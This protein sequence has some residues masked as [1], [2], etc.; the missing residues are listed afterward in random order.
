MQVR[1]T[2]LFDVA[3]VG[4]GIVGLATAW[5]ILQRR[6]STRLI[7]LEKEARVAMHQSSRNSG[8]IHSG[9]YYRPGSLRAQNCLRG[10]RLLLD[11]C[12]HHD[13]PYAICGKLI[14]ATTE[15]ERPPLE[16]LHRRG[17]E[18]GLTGV[19]LLSGAEAREIEPY[20]N[21]AAALWVPQTGI[22]DYGAVARQLAHLVEQAGGLIRVNAE[23]ER[24]TPSSQGL[25]IGARSWEGTARY[26]VTCAGL[27]ADRLARR[28]GAQFDGQI[29][30]FR[31]EYYELVPERT[32]LVQHPIYPVPNPNF[33]FLGVHFTPKIGGEVEAGPN[34]VLAFRREGYRRQDVSWSDLA[35]TFA[36]RGFR[37]LACRHWREGWSEIQRSFS[38]RHFVHA[39]QR[40][41][42]AIQP[43]DLMPTRSGVRAMLCTAD[44]HLYDDF[45]FEEGPQ[46]LHVLN[47]PSPAATASLAI[48]ETLAEK[49]LQ[50]LR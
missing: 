38:K 39:L 12:R 4:G 44:G 30:P 20:V 16:V 29:L 17:L 22:T 11:F 2:S 28:S 49:V 6:P 50:R 41:I 8:V 37:R 48:G 45:F 27:Y 9:I 3:V 42:P 26:A 32:H 43:D 36:F 23:V 34:A 19:R 1:S 31:G 5:Q 15:E 10:Y 35:E 24:L 21:A 14:V 33:P 46:V 40:L 47:A 13:L 25:R 18:N 7:V